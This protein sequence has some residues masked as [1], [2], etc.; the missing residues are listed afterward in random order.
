MKSI[1]IVGMTKTGKTTE[2]K[3]ILST[4]PE[5]K[6]YIYDVNRE[7]TDRDLPD[8]QSFIETAKKAKN[9]VIVFEEA[10]IFFSNRGRSEDVTNIL[11]R[12]RHTGN[13]IVFCFH[14]L[15]S[16]P[17]S[18]FELIDYVYI[19]RTN[20]S[21]ASVKRKFDSENLNVIFENVKK[22]S[23]LDPYFTYKVKGA[24]L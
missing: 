18:I 7:Y 11:V 9:S 2:V 3:K 20:D 17:L 10:T 15:R 1:L 16:I 14:S 21:F 23:K 5:R 13:I 4:F 12:K 6:K 8:L 19:K 22:S 24:D